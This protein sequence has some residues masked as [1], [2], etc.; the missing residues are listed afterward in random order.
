MRRRHINRQ[1]V[2][3]FTIKG[4]TTGTINLIAGIDPNPPD[5]Y[6]NAIFYIRM[7]SQ[8][9]DTGKPCKTERMWLTLND[10]TRLSILMNIASRFWTNK[11]EKG[12]PYTEEKILEFVNEYSDIKKSLMKLLP[13]PKFPK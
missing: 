5:P 9:R 13:K 1:L 10:M 6:P 4:G 7:E 8:D 11:Y 3:K 2:D 12:E